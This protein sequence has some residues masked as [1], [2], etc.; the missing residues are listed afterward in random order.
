MNLRAY[1]PK[2]ELVGVHGFEPW[3]SCT[4]CRRATELRHTPTRRRL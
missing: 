4:P 2:L 3:A 1:P